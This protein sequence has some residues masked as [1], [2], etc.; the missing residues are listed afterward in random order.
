MAMTVYTAPYLYNSLL[1]DM[2]ISIVDIICYQF[3]Q[4]SG[5]DWENLTTGLAYNMPKPLRD[6]VRLLQGEVDRC[7]RLCHTLHEKLHIL[8]NTFVL[9]CKMYGADIDLIDHLIEV[10]SSDRVFHTPY[11]ILIESIINHRMMG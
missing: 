10:L 6:K 2:E 9:R 5:R 4:Y 1:S 3:D 11:R 7:D 8:L